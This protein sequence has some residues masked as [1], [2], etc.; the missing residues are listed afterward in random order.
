ML[1]IGPNFIEPIK[2]DVPTD[3]EHRL[4][5]SDLE[6]DEKEEAD[7]P[8]LGVKVYG[9]ESDDDDVDYV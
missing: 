5:D 8:D 3:E 6:S 1:S 9:P 2:D 7:N 4:R